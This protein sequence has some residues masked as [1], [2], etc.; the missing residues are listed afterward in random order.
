MDQT[1]EHQLHLLLPWRPC[2]LFLSVPQT[3][4]QLSLSNR[5]SSSRTTGVLLGHGQNC[6]DFKSIHSKCWKLL[7]VANSALVL[8][9][10]VSHITTRCGPE[11]W[12]C[13]CGWMFVPTRFFCFLLYIATKSVNKC[14]VYCMGVRSP[15]NAVDPIF[16]GGV[17]WR[18][19]LEWYR[20]VC[21]P[22]RTSDC[23]CCLYAAWRGPNMT[24]K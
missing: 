13:L 16:H 15:N 21:S 17:R 5:T 19:Y 7:R 20:R 24:Y 2:R 11:V 3:H 10:S 8:H 9:S 1:V 18:M 22:V 14:C 6:N 23:N 12:L 4:L